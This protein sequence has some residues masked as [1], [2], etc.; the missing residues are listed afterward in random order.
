MASK[1]PAASAQIE[2]RILVDTTLED[3]TRLPCN[4]VATLS[5]ESA[6]VLVAAGAADDTPEAV[7]AAKA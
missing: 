7:Q 1:K 2:V 6:A 4:S 3:G 5:A